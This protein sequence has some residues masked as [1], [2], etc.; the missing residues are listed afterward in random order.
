MQ[1]TGD[2]WMIF[3]HEGSRTIGMIGK[4]ETVWL[5]GD[6]A[7]CRQVFAIIKRDEERDG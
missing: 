3:R 6:P 1:R 2:W 5:E 7:Y 4:S